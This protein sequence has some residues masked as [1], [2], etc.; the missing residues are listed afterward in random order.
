V[1]RTFDKGWGV[2]CPNPIKKGEFIAEYVGEMMHNKVWCEIR[3]SLSRSIGFCYSFNLDYGI[4]AESPK[5]DM[6]YM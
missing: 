4:A 3:N 6:L 2:R 5:D 1:F